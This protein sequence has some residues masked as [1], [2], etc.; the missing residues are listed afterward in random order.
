MNKKGFTL[1]ELL[2]VIVVLSIIA[3][4]TTPLVLNT[5]DVAKRDSFKA[6]VYNIAET[7]EKQYYKDLLVGET[8]KTIIYSYNN[9]VETSNVDTKVLEY[10]GTKPKDGIVIV[11]KEGKIKL[12]LHNGVWCAK[13]D[14][15]EDIVK[16]TKTSKEDCSEEVMAPTI[17]LISGDIVIDMGEEF[18][19][20]G[21]TAIDIDGQDLTSLVS[22]VI[23]KNG[24]TVDQINTNELGEYEIYYTYNKDDIYVEKVRRVKIKDTIPPVIEFTDNVEVIVFQVE[25]FDL[26]SGVTVSDN[27]GIEPTVTISGNLSSVEGTYQ[28]TYTVTDAAGNVTEKVR[29][30]K[31]VSAIFNFDYTGGR[32][33]WSV[34]LSGT[35]LLEVWGAQGGGNGGKGGYS[36][37]N[38]TLSQ[39]DLLYIYVGGQGEAGA[40]GNTGRYGGFNGGGR[41]GGYSTSSSTYCCGGYG[42][43]GAGSEYGA[44]YAGGGGSGY[45]GGVTSG[46]TIAGNASM[47]NPSGGTITGKTGNGYAR[48]TYLR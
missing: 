47:P 19:D 21:Y 11:S 40:S 48:I 5:I 33:T 6:S 24:V 9:G 44:I 37:G 17:E 32:Q 2:A 41:G 43:G 26:M 1:I 46:Q 10:K 3:L 16:L 27:S 28:I 12:Q 38:I 34:P 30:I 20:P 35:Y 23:K 22:I 13:K 7:A 45:I 8:K 29:T 39:G 31:V 36:K 14:Y 25:T 4:I 42:G 15:N 18:T